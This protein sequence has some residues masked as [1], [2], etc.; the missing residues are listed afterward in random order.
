M[1]N[2]PDY[3]K[4]LEE[5]LKAMKIQLP[6]GIL[7]KIKFK[8]ST[9]STLHYIIQLRRTE[10]LLSIKD[11][12]LITKIRTKFAFKRLRKLGFL[13]SYEIH[14]FSFG[15]GLS[16]YHN[17]IIVNSKV[18]AG[19]NC[20]LRAYSVIGSKTVGDLEFCPQIGDN[21]DIGCNCSVIGGIKIGDNVTV[22]AGSVVV[23]DLPSNSICVGNP[24]KVV[25]FK[26]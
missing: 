5:D 25:K 11:K 10:Q 22:G 15:P 8:L 18:K 4:Y 13:L 17:G 2:A 1:D 19:K 21:V 14:P 20:T 6:K 3:K 24:A 9:P 23:T 7:S 26:E 12:N 16:L